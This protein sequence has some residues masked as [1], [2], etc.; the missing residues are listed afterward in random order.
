M[1]EIAFVELVLTYDSALR[2]EAGSQ[3]PKQIRPTFNTDT[4]KPQPPKSRTVSPTNPPTKK[5]L[6]NLETEFSASRRGPNSKTSNCEAPCLL[7]GQQGRIDRGLNT[8]SLRSER[9]QPL[10]YYT[11]STI[12][13]NP[14]NSRGNDLGPYLFDPVGP[15][16]DTELGLNQ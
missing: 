6:S 13:R 15:L 12:I 5:A 9:Q 8:L 14:Q 16:T 4:L 1:L 10:I 7:G 11:R 2:F 3:D